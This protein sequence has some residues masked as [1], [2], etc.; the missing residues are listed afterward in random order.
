MRRGMSSVDFRTM[1]EGDD[2]R[3]WLKPSVTL[4]CFPT[5]PAC[6]PVPEEPTHPIS[7][8]LWAVTDVPGQQQDV[9]W[10]T[11]RVE[12]GL[13][14]YEYG[15]LPAA[16]YRTPLSIVYGEVATHNH[17]VLDRGGKVFKQTAPVIKLPP[18]H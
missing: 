3:D 16:S 1:V 13:T 2:V 14:W 5:M 18:R 8:Y 12:D 9:R 17:F 7:R 10:K 6:M 11:R 15:G 4:P